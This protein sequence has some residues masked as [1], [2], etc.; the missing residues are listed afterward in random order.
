VEAY[1]LAW[2]ATLKTIVEKRLDEPGLKIESLAGEMFVSERTFRNKL[3]AYT[4]LSPAEYLMKM[5]L[6]R[7]LFLLERRRYAT[8]SEVCHAVGLKNPSHF[9][10]VFKEE[11]G[12]LPSE[13]FR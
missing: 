12:K 4:G 5:R 6:A 13:Y 11:Y 7:A 10:K 3:R 9:T 8:I 1:D 2:L